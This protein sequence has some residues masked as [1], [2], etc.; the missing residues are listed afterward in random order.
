VRRLGLWMVVAGASMLIGIPAVVGCGGDEGEPLTLEQ[1]LPT[2]DELPGFEQA[3]T[4]PDVF[5]DSASFAKAIEDSLVQATVTEATDVFDEAGFVSAIGREFTKTGDDEAG[6]YAVVLEFD[7]EEGVERASEWRDEDI[8]K[9]CP[10]RCSVDI[11]EFE[12]DGISGATPGIRRTVTQERLEETGEK[13]QPFDSYEVGFNDGPLAYDILARGPPGSVTEEE[14]VA[15]LNRL[16]ERVK[17][18][19]LPDE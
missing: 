9:P 18:A 17:G 14:A 16:Y 13:G 12:V 4:T 7:S 3:S 5:T 1:R 8:R 11:S 10:R 19:P 2:V 6:L 15:A